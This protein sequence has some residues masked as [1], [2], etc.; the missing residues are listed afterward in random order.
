M[1]KGKSAAKIRFSP[2]LTYKNMILAIIPAR[3]ASTRFPGKPLAKIAGKTMIQRVFEQVSQSARVDVAVIATDDER[4]FEHAKS[5]GAPVVMTKP[6]HPSG[7]DRCAEAALPYPDAE[8]I[9]NV[10]GDEPFISP[11]QIDLLADTLSNHPIAT[12]ATLVKKLEHPEHLFNSNVV[13]AVFSEKAGAIYF[14]RHPIPFVRNVEE[15]QWF[16]QQTFYKHIGLYAFRRGTLM[17]IT[18]LSPT[19]LE[20]S[21][22]LEQLRWLEHGYRIA[23]G[24]TQLETIGIDTPQDLAQAEAYLSGQ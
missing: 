14:S 20:K 11:Q 2:T 12:I 9:L 10:Q 24:I 15:S 4:I 21:E 16:D 17:E 3:W 6:D 19:P 13:K 7:T 5:F 8:I 1:A 18:G 22:S 23:V